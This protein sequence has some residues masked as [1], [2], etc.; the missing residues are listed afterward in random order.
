MKIV[1]LSRAREWFFA[2]L[3]LKTKG[4]EGNL[5]KKICLK[6]EKVGTKKRGKGGGD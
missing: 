2:K 4:F 1:L 3:P 5:A 6:L